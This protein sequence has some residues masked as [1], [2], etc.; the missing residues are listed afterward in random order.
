MQYTVYKSNPN[1][2]LKEK[3]IPPTLAWEASALLPPHQKN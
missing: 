1:I 3:L 2:L